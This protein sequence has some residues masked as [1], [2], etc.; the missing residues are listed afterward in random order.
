MQGEGQDEDGITPHGDPA[1]RHARLDPVRTQHRRVQQWMPCARLMTEE[2]R[3]QHPAAPQRAE[4]QQQHP[5]W[6][7]QQEYG[8]PGQAEEVGTDHQPADDLPQRD[9]EGEHHAVETDRPA[10]GGPVPVQ[11]DEREDLRSEQRRPHALPDPGEH[12]RGRVRGQP[13]QQR[14]AGEPAQPE[15]ERPPLPDD[16]T[17]PRARDDEH[18]GGQ[19]VARHD[20]LDRGAAGVQ[21]VTNRLRRHRHDRAVHGRHDLAGEQHGQHP[22]PAGGRR[23]C[24]GKC[25]HS[26]SIGGTY[27]LGLEEICGTELSV[28][29]RRVV[30][31]VPRRG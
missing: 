8:P 24:G 1:G 31:C 2:P 3:Q 6:D 28:P 23:R 20:Q 25:S 9:P 12:H 10:A 18:A 17:D 26:P 11:L 30:G 29:V 4:H 27:A 14:R 13:A 5:N 16:V 22:A 15:Q 7:V 21:I 19:Q